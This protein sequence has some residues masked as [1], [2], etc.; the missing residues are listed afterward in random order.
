MSAHQPIDATRIDTYDLPPI[1]WSHIREQL[2]TSWRLQGGGGQENRTFW[3]A[4]VRPDGRPHS[5]AVGALWTD[6]RLF[7]TSG[8]TT[9]K[10]QNLGTNP[11]CTMS[12]S[13]ADVD[14]AIEGRAAR[15]TDPETLERAAALYR[16][17]GWPAQVDGDAL[18]APFSAPSAGKAPWYLWEITP[19]V[20]FGVGTSEPGGAMRWRFEE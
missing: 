16:D 17:S 9:R 6:D 18:T 12:V 1:E 19:H 11:A 15:V 8:P 5:T 7:F 2:D 3:L 20:A 4:T 14:L 13:L 10:S